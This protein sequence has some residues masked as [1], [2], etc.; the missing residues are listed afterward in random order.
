MAAV[1]SKVVA[2]FDAAAAD[3]DDCASN[4][5][6]NCDDGNVFVEKKLLLSSSNK[7]N[8]ENRADASI[9]FDKPFVSEWHSVLGIVFITEPNVSVI[10]GCDDFSK[11]VLFCCSTTSI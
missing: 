6:K 10:N 3:V 9:T 1:P 11:L 8:L 7:A 4:L 5:L 2:V